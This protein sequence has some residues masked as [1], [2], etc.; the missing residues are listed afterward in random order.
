MIE[1][2]F[3]GGFGWFAYGVHAG[4]L[5][6]IGVN[7]ERQLYLGFGFKNKHGSRYV[8]IAIL[9]WKRSRFLHQNLQMIQ[10]IL[11]FH[12][13]QYIFSSLL[14][15][16]QIPSHIL[17]PQPMLLPLDKLPGVD[18]RPFRQRSVRVLLLFQWVASRLN[19]KVEGGCV[20]GNNFHEVGVRAFI[21]SGWI[22]SFVQ[23]LKLHFTWH[24][25]R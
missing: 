4:G 20:G 5:L 21:F 17:L 7:P 13:S 3:F 12:S 2:L 11:I 9:L 22:I 16:I 1:L 18:L 8:K 14:Y 6:G 25:P 23:G 24:R 10:L 19:I 15:N